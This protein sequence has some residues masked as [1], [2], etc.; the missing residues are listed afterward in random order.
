MPVL[1]IIHIVATTRLLG[2]KLPG[3]FRPCPN[4]KSEQPPGRSVLQRIV[5]AD[6]TTDSAPSL[7]RRDFMH[8]ILNKCFLERHLNPTSHHPRP[9]VLPDLE[10]QVL[11]RVHH[12]RQQGA[13]DSVTSN[14]LCLD[15][16]TAIARTALWRKLETR[17]D[18]LGEL[19]IIQGRRCISCRSGECLPFGARAQEPPRPTLPSYSAFRMVKIAEFCCIRDNGCARCGVGQPV[20]QEGT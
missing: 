14:I 13:I 15:K 12:P 6:V 2:D 18:E 8:L 16:D 19:T 17:S 11:I 10:L 1:V 3:I 5:M 7:C 9:A 20:D 4:A